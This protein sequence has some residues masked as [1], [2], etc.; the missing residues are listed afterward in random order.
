[1]E[2]VMK[3]FVVVL[4]LVGMFSVASTAEA[5]WYDP[6]GILA[7]GVNAIAEAVII[8]DKAAEGV[9]EIAHGSI[10]HPLGVWGKDLLSEVVTLGAAE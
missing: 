5:A 4:A 2:G 7:G 9:W 1:M 6:R 10:L 3:K 8:V